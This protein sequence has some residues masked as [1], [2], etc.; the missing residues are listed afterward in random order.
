MKNKVLF[1]HK[2]S[3]YSSLNLLWYRFRFA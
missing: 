3:L 2:C 1:Y